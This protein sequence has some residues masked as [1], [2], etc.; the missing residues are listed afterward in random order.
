MFPCVQV[1]ASTATVQRLQAPRQLRAALLLAG[2]RVSLIHLGQETELLCAH[3]AG[4]RARLCATTTGSVACHLSVQQLQL[5]N[6]DPAAVY[7]VIAATPVQL[8]RTPAGWRPDTSLPALSL[9]AHAERR[10]NGAAVTALSAQV[11]RAAL[12]VRAPSRHAFNGCR[13]DAVH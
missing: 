5:D 7:P 1:S 6:C 4:V 8:S 12:Q 10:P 11:A 3:I 2:V 9:V 13:L